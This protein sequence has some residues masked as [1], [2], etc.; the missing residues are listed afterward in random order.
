MTR[1]IETSLLS[2]RARDYFG[3]DVQGFWIERSGG[4]APYRYELSQRPHWGN[5]RVAA[6]CYAMTADEA[7]KEF[8]AMAAC[9][10]RDRA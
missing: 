9:A 1:E 8:D 5:P 6:S 4:K 3:G 7:R 10:D 2:A